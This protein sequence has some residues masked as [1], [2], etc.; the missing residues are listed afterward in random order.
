MVWV[1]GG[2][3]DRGVASVMMGL[4][5]GLEGEPVHCF[6]KGNIEVMTSHNFLPEIVA[7]SRMEEKGIGIACP[8]SASSS[9]SSTP[10]SEMEGDRSLF[11]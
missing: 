3:D 4:A 7:S 10:S 2:R 11:I 9:P 1:R 8:G 6:F 5:I